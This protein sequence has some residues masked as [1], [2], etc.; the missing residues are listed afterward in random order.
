M[1]ERFEVDYYGN[2]IQKDTEL[3]KNI[4]I[5]VKDLFERNGWQYAEINHSGSYRYVTLIKGDKN[6][7]IN[8]YTGSVRNE[9]RNPY[10]KKIQLGSNVSPD[11][12]SVKDD[13]GII[14]GFYVFN[15]DDDIEKTLVVAYPIL[16][17]TRYETNPSLRG[18]VF[19]NKILK[20]ARDKG[21]VVNDQ[22]VVCFRPD[23]IFYYLDNYKSLHN[24]SSE[25][26]NNSIDNQSE[27]YKAKN[28]EN[29]IFYGAPGCGKSYFVKK[30]L[31]DLG[32]VRKNRI[33]V[34]F[35]PDYSNSDFVGQILPSVEERI[36]GDTG[37]KEEIVKYSF[38]PGPFTLALLQTY[39]TNNMV[40]LIIEEINRG[41][42]A[43]IFGDLFQLL[44]REKDKT[45][46]NYNE[47]EYA[48]DNPI[49]QRY[50]SDRLSSEGIAYDDRL[51]IPS[52]LTIYATMNSSDQNVFTMDTA[53]KRRWN[54][55]HIS[56]D[57]NTDNNHSY[58]NW[59]IPGTDVTWARFLTKVNKKILKNK[60][61][62][63]TN[64]DKQ[65]G[66]YFVTKDCLT[67][68]RNAKNQEAANNFAYKVLEYL[69][70]DVCKIGK[71]DWF[72]TSK[73]E[74]LEDLI[75]NFINPAPNCNPLSVFQDIN[76]QE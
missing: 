28:G 65:M 47:S 64:E 23:F 40:Y 8:L 43:A 74:T 67:E 38:F 22:Q 33:R 21:L 13:N 56:N 49:I 39:K 26:S 11:P 58:K 31:D 5:L 24:Y 41:N 70:N 15:E 59:Y 51:V 37:E 12:H 62:N 71:S 17:N 50:L 57:I 14:L 66:K 76:F 16:D 7:K 72:D 54:F 6:Y 60:I 1:P 34:T 32:V 25:I 2:I 4:D 69:W 44:D 9:A 61:S 18:G 53:F 10:E 27:L 46:Q 3:P 68:E 35:H 55:E 19:T 29:K 36:N 20:E 45:K 63:Q 52:N 42:A 30:S 48:I 75:K 73:Y